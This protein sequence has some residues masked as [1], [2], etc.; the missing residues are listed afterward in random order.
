MLKK[1][2]DF[3][4]SPVILGFNVSPQE[5]SLLREEQRECLNYCHC[6]SQSIKKML[7]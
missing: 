4:D 7:F 3:H 2:V 5:Q 6:P 1:A